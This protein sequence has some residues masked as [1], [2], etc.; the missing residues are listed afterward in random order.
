[1][2]DHLFIYEMIME[3]DVFDVFLDSL[4]KYFIEHFLHQCS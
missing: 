4:C 1:M 3:D 2:L